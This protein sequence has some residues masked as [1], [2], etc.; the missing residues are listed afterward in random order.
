M[1]VLFLFVVFIFIFL[2]WYQFLVRDSMPHRSQPRQPFPLG[3][4]RASMSIDPLIIPVDENPKRIPDRLPQVNIDYVPTMAPLPERSLKQQVIPTFTT[5]PSKIEE[6]LL[7]RSLVLAMFSIGTIAVDLAAGTHFSWVAIPFV[8]IGSAWSWYRRHEAKEGVNIVVSVASLAIVFGVFVQI[9]FSQISPA[10]NLV[11]PPS[12]LS[13]VLELTIGAIAILIQ[14]GLCFHLYSRRVLGYCLLISAILI[15]VAAG[16]SQSI[17]FFVLLCGFM[18]ASIPALMLDYRSRLA[19]PPIGIQLTP[20][21]GQLSYQHLPWKYL[22]RLAA[23]AIGLGMIFSIFLSI[24]HFPDLSL[25]PND[26]NQIQP[27]VPQIQPP[28]TQN[29]DPIKPPSPQVPNQSNLD[30]QTLASKV[31]GQ[32]SNNYYPNQIKQDNLQLPSEIIGQLQQF[33]QQILA[34]SPQPLN[35]D[36]DRSTYLAE[37]LKKQHKD[38]LVTSNNLPPLDS[39]LIRQ[40]ITNCSTKP[41]ACELIGNRQDLPVVYTS[42][43]RSIGIPARLTAGTELAQ[44]DP[45]TQLYPRLSNFNSQTEVYLPNW[46]W[47]G[48]DAR[49]DRL[50]INS[51]ERQQLDQI[52]VRLEQQLASIPADPAMIAPTTQPSPSNAN[53]PSNSPKSIDNSAPSPDQPKPSP[54]ANPPKDLDLTIFK[55]IVIIVAIIGG[56]AWY[57]RHRKQEQQQ[58]ATLPPIERIYRSMILGLS[59]TGNTKVPAQTQL[60]YAHSIKNTEHPQIAKLVSEISH[61]YTAWRYG[62]E[63][64]D[65]QHLAKKLQ[66]LQHLQQLAA[67]RQRQQWIAKQK[68]LWLGNTKKPP[69]K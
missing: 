36:F 25:K 57:L 23:M 2:W 42:M 51:N 4:S 3:S 49:P 47:F 44:I 45:Q 9:I 6:S 17:G 48:L 27:P 50:L 54:P 43:L 68:S 32:P 14:M 16:L 1:G 8:S 55:A 29:R 62:K 61:L 40:L 12:K 10:V 18:L 60:E 39:Q 19:L 65:A 30:I 33:T 11:A 46:G 63:K 5:N 34:T 13:A 41:E 38:A 52:R 56:I 59:K 20:P 7:F 67:D 37:Y 69:I 24:V 28:V 64:I 66:N 53:P 22:A 58:L 35:S 15:G 26:I 31:L 21:T